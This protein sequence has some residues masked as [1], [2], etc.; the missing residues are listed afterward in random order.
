MQSGHRAVSKQEI[1]ALLPLLK[2]TCIFRLLMIRQSEPRSR[3][4]GRQRVPV[5]RCR[6]RQHYQHYA[7]TAA[8]TSSYPTNIN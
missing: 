2:K 1:Y 5:D 7:A 4:A 8:A 6:K 3:G